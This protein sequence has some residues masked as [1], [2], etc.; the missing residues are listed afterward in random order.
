MP[1]VSICI[2]AYNGAPYLAECIESALAQSFGDIEVLVVDDC[3]VDDTVA[4]ARS[5]ARRDHRVHV[6]QNSSNLGLVGNWNHSVRLARGEWVKFLHQDDRLAADCV[7]QMLSVAKPGVDLVAV[8]R[9]ILFHND[10]EDDLK[11]IYTRYTS[12]HDIARH[13]P[14][15]VYISAE[16]FAR[17]VLRAPNGNCIG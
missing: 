4:I 13:F 10:T 6:S 15:Q 9:Q 14:G 17:V 2:P 8:R 11:H 3:S 1:L 5:Y 12:E 16:E 7:E